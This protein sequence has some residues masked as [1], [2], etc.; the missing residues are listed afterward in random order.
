M[1]DDFQVPDDPGYFYDNYGNSGV[2]K[3][4]YLSETIS[5]YG[6]F[7]FFPS[8]PSSTETGKRRGAIIL[9]S[10]ALVEELRQVVELRE[11]PEDKVLSKWRNEDQR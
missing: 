6:L 8:C 3:L 5:Q 10:A 2:L 9:T 7:P 11:L 4:D 1:V